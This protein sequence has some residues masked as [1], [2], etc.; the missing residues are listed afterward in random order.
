[1]LKSKRDQGLIDVERTV[2]YSNV[3]KENSFVL[4]N[5]LCKLYLVAYVLILIIMDHKLCDVI[6]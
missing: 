4:Q 1:M 5:A 6:Q 3:Y 2:V